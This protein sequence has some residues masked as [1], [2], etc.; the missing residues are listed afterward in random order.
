MSS[1][2]SD[3][4]WQEFLDLLIKLQSNEDMSEFLRLFLAVEERNH[5]ADRFLVIKSLLNEQNSQRKISKDLGVSIAKI[6]RCSN[7]LKEISG[8][9]RGYLKDNIL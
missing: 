4:G 1:P 9:L 7:S 2:I 5:I 6:T 3:Q 8:D